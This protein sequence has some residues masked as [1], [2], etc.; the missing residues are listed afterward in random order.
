MKKYQDYGQFMIAVIE[1]ADRKCGIYFMSSLLHVFKLPDSAKN[2]FSIINSI[3]EV[4]WLAF[5]AVCALLVLGP[6][7]FG[8]ALLT[9]VAGGVGA[10]VIAAVALYG[11]IQAIRLL[12]NNRIA[13]LAI[14]EVG[15]QYKPR[16]DSHV[17]EQSYIDRLIDE[18]S[19]ELIGKVR[20]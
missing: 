18:A 6:W 13:P 8:M 14:Y 10:V 5:A 12:Y 17:G 7:A 2:I 20:K 11:G 4:G 3:F 15:S 9:F 16:F 1:E 19:D